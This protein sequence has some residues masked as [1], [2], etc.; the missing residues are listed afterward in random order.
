MI[1][2]EMCDELRIVTKV[3]QWQC[4]GECIIWFK[5]IQNQRGSTFLKYGIKDFYPFISCETLD[6]AINFSKKYMNISDQQVQIIKH[7]SKSIL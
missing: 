6:K 2:K 3:N 1:I 7:C 4:T 5:N